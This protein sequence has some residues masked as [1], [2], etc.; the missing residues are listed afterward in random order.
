MTDVG[1]SSS[2]LKTAVDRHPTAVADQASTDPSGVA[3]G[4]AAATVHPFDQLALGVAF[5]DR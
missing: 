4:V 5:H 2:W 3:S 1:S